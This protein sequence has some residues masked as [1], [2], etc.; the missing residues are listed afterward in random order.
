MKS[1]LLQIEVPA[2]LGND[3]DGSA[4]KGGVEEDEPPS[5]NSSLSLSA[6]FTR[7]ECSKSLPRRTDVSCKW[8]LKS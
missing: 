6:Y 2:R 8:K 4:W 1:F 3:E 5:T 7:L